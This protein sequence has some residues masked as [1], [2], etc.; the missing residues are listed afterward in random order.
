MVTGQLWLPVSSVDPTLSYDTYFTYWP[1]IVH[2]L[3]VS[4]LKSPEIK[5]SPRLP[6]ELKTII[7]SPMIMSP[8]LYDTDMMTSKQVIVETGTPAKVRR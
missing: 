1:Y 8:D 4:L 7:S 6:A 2:S 5:M 3:D